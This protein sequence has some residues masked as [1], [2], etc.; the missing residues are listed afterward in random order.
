MK[1]LS[2]GV[3]I[4]VLSMAC[5]RSSSPTA[6]TPVV[7]TP[8][9]PTAAIPKVVSISIT[10]S[11]ETVMVNFTSVLFANAH[12]D[13]G[14]SA[15]ITPTWESSSSLVTLLANGPVAL[16][17]GQGVGTAVI[18]ARA[19]GFSATQSLTVNPLQ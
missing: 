8:A 15:P 5:G 9:P 1:R 7:E 19:A 2:F 10:A 12:Y 4:L 3:V 6:P 14:S 13:D 11:R 18:T 16:A 17:T